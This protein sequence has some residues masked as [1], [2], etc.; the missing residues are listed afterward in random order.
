MAQAFGVIHTGLAILEQAFRGK[1][2]A[3]FRRIALTRV[4]GSGRQGRAFANF[5]RQIARFADVGTRCVTTNAIDAIA[6]C[7]LHVRGA[8]QRTRRAF[9]ATAIDARFGAILNSV[10]AR[11]ALIIFARGI[12]AGAILI[13]DAFDA[14]AL[15]IAKTTCIALRSGYDE[16]RDAFPIDAGHRSTDRNG[17]AILDARTIYTGTGAGTHSAISA[18]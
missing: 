2:T 4:F 5:I 18:S 8:A 7:A 10:I 17:R 3:C 6:T 13:R 12:V 16:S 15:A 11:N 9:R 1:T 14:R